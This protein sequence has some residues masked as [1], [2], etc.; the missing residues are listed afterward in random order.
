MQLAWL[1]FFHSS[2]QSRLDA[3]TE[4]FEPYE[5]QPEFKY[6]LPSLLLARTQPE[7]RNASFCSLH[8][9]TPLLP[10]FILLTAFIFVSQ[11]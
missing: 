4:R 6:V 7:P 10:F 8:F 3:M 9:A 5:I 11:G 1:D 2:R